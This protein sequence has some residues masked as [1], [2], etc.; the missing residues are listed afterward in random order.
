MM[1][2]PIRPSAASIAKFPDAASRLEFSPAVGRLIAGDEPAGFVR[3]RNRRMIGRGDEVFARARRAIASRQMFRFGWIGVE[4][5]DSPI[6][7]DRTVAILARTFGLWTMN[8]A[9]IF[10]TI[11]DFEEFGFNYGS[12]PGHSKEEIEQ[13]SVT[14]D[15]ADG[16][17]WYGLHAVSRPGRLYA[18]LSYPLTR[19]VQGRLA[20]DSMDAVA[21]FVGQGKPS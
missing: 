8:P 2:S 11:D 6:E 12:L 18:K 17:V 9:R 10:R 20:I 14:R 21:T 19:R 15:P 4:P 16:C 5:P 7:N 13:I 3:D 1:P